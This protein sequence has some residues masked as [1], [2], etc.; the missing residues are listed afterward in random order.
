MG[1]PPE[2]IKFCTSFRGASK[3]SEVHHPEVIGGLALAESGPAAALAFHH[4]V[5]LF[6]QALALAIFAFL[7]FLDVG[8]FGIGHDILRRLN[9]TTMIQA[10]SLVYKHGPTDLRTAHD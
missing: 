8:A 9:L 10:H 1:F 3:A 6:Q 4:L 7:L 5:A 2:L